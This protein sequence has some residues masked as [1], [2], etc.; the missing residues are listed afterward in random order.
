MNRLMKRLEKLEQTQAV[1]A[2]Q[3]AGEQSKRVQSFLRQMCRTALRVV[4]SDDLKILC[5]LRSQDPSRCGE[6]QFGDHG[7]ISYSA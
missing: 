6:D 2:A 3:R 5:E 1:A 4:S 7:S